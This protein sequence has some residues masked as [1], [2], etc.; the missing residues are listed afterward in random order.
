MGSAWPGAFFLTLAAEGAVGALLGLRTRPEL[1]AVA[2]A[3]LVT[4]PALFYMTARSLPAGLWGNAG[5]GLAL[6]ESGAVLL[7]AA[8]LGYALPD[9]RRGSLLALSLAMN[10]GS[11]LFGAAFLWPA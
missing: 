9:R 1:A 3:N 10:L 7:E 4:H 5:A 11:F 6:L 2:A 8:L